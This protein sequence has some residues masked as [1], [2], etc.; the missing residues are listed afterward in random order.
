MNAPCCSPRR[1]YRPATSASRPISAVSSMATAPPAR[2]RAAAR[3]CEAPPSIALT[4]PRAASNTR[5][6]AAMA[7]IRTPADVTLATRSGTPQPIAKLSSSAPAARPSG[8]DRSLDVLSADIA[9]LTR[10]GSVHAPCGVSCPEPIS[11]VPTAV[12]RRFRMSPGVLGETAT[13]ETG[14][15]RSQTPLLQRH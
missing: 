4:I 11:P 14:A 2:T 10:N 15:L 6:D 12:A 1:P 9:G 7:A 5:V 3:R 13:S 8:H